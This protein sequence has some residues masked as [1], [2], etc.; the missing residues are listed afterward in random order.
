MGPYDRFQGTPSSAWIYSRVIAD[1]WETVL[2][3]LNS[4]TVRCENIACSSKFNRS[5]AATMSKELSV[6]QAAQYV[7]PYRLEK[8]LGK[9][10]TGKDMLFKY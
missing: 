4:E 7:G 2:E 9:G 5:Q 10:Q 1:P 3:K 8:T 6:T